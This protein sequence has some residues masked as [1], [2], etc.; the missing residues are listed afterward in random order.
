MRFVLYS[1]RKSP[2]VSGLIWRIDTTQ[3]GKASIAV[4]PTDSIPEVL[5]TGCPDRFW[6]VSSLSRLGQYLHTDH[7]RFSEISGSHSDEYEDE[8]VSGYRAVYSRRSWTTF[9][10]CVLPLSSGRWVMLWW[11][12]WS[13]T[14]L[15]NVVCFYEFTHCTIPEG[16][17]L[18]YR[19]IP[20]FHN[21]SVTLI[22]LRDQELA[23]ARN[24]WR[25]S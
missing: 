8:S 15:W 18:H 25:N 13:R 17:Q 4:Q 22:Q 23:N 12:W 6:W 24:A 5:E 9:Q 7:D 19:F 11:L 10:G 1:R 16:C 3:I 20:Q 14:H 2:F 21:S